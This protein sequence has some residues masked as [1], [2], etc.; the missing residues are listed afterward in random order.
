[1]AQT[2]ADRQAAAQKAA[3]TRE[4][5]K[6]RAESSERGHKAASTRFRNQ[7]EDSLKDARRAA[8]AVFSNTKKAVSALGDAAVKAGKS[9]A[10]RVGL[11]SS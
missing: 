1:M 11:L 6:V 3:A 9:V 7:A 2:K 10:S 8:D 4:R 5:N